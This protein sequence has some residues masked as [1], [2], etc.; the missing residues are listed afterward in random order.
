MKV[1]RTLRIRI[2]AKRRPR[3]KRFVLDLAQFRNL[4]LIFQDRYHKL[5]GQFILNESVIYSLLAD[6][7]KNKSP[8]QEEALREVSVRVMEDPELK[9][10]V[11][12]M[13][14]QKAKLDNNYVLQTAIRQVIK[15][16]RGFLNS[17]TEYRT[18]PA[19]FKEQPRPP[20]PK[21]L[22]TIAQVTA[23]FNS[24]AFE[25]T[26]R[27]LVLRL[28][29][30]GDEKIKIKLPAGIENVSSVR[31]TYH[32]SDA[33]VDVVYERE[34]EAPEGELCYL[35]GIDLG[36]DNLVSLI[37]TNPRVRSLIVSGKEIKSFNRWFNKKAA[38]LRSAIDTLNNKVAEEKDE[39]RKKSMLEELSELR[40][41]FHNLCNYR[42]RWIETQFH[43]IARILADFLYETGHKKVYIGSGATTSKDGINL[44]RVTNQNLMGIP[45]RRFISILK[46]KLEELGVQAEEKDE[47]YTSKASSLSD[48]ILE[49]QKKYAEAKEKQENVT[50]KCSGKRIE[51][52]LYRDDALN[53]VFNADLNGALNILK[54]GAQLREVPLNFKVLLYKLSTPLKFTL[55]EFIY[56][57]KS[58]AESLLGIGNSRLATAG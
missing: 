48:D 1:K 15:D 2:S 12:R 44:G 16:Y 56:G 49:I 17:I 7:T 13:K 50:I 21:K 58:K 45:F 51:R 8:E 39:A 10:L 34:L 3:V 14:E 52:G 20:R 38:E 40:L 53:K 19:K 30:K 57:F 47:P 4:F 41:Y 24:N 23:E 22:K 6:K 11:G 32:L 46:Y 55:Y 42:R 9:A 18:S 43:R 28:R 31:L 25:A 33:W 54:V 5:F 35:A 29:V 26:S 27:A 37:S 36:L